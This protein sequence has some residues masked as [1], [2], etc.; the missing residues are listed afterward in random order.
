MLK[1]KWTKLWG[2][3]D[4]TK[5]LKKGSQIKPYILLTRN[6]QKR[7]NSAKKIKYFERNGWG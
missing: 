3:F 6:W 1:T 2:N 5:K 7:K 4:F